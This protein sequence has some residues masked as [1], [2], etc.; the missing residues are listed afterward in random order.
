MFTNYTDIFTCLKSDIHVLG[1]FGFNVFFI[2]KIKSLQAKQNK[3]Y[4]ANANAQECKT[5]PLTY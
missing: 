1:S 2:L 5:N 4:S 3:G